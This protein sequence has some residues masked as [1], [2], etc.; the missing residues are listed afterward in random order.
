MKHRSV[1][2]TRN[3]L[4]AV[5][6]IVLLGILL[7]AVPR[8]EAVAMSP[9]TFELFANPGDKI[10]NTLSIRNDTD[11]PTGVSISVEDFIAAGEEGRVALESSEGPSSYSLSKWV[12]VSPQT[13][14]LDPHGSQAVE[15]IIDVPLDAEPGGH[16]SS[17][18]ANVGAASQTEGGV[19]VAS[20]VGS[21]VLLNVAGDVK[22]SV[23][24]AEFSTP[25]YSEFGPIS[26]LTRFE[27]TGTVHTKPR[28]F[29]LIKDMFGREVDKIV[30]D[31]KNVLPNSI[32]RMEVEWG[33]K[34][35]F[36]RY[37]ATL[38]A[39]YG[40]TNEPL[41]SV[42]TFWVIP[43]KIA[44]AVGL[45]VLLILIMLIK[46]RKRIRLAL[47]IIFKGTPKHAPAPK[48]RKV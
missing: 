44:S 22:E 30:L 14:T 35:M 5:S 2:I 19:G 40:T 23:R 39:I 37:E 45:I 10:T 13:F 33:K 46:G 27:N 25:N 38:A 28:G 6:G 41:S 18:L 9:L 32:R 34:Y 29:I 7:P 4:A 17:V 47:R 8:A 24:V 42:T 16:Y 43:W 48:K 26:I 36:G 15:F 21:L 3:L 20:K 11:A 12:T 31:Q 1:S